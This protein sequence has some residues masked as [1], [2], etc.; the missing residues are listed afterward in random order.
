MGTE[1]P[2]AEVAK[3]RRE[4]SRL[5]FPLR[6]SAPSAV[7]RTNLGGFDLEQEPQR[8]LHFTLAAARDAVGADGAGDR[9]ERG[10]STEIARRLIEVRRV[11][12]VVK[13]RAEFDA[14]VLGNPE[15]FE[16]RE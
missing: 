15:M 10:W 14:L 16:D 6:T 9:S 12:Q 8:E 4:Q 2:T 7:S 1:I 11:G 3:E 5:V 13:F